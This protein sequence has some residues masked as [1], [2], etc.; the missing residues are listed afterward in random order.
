MERHVLARQ[1]VR[2]DDDV[3]LPLTEICEDGAKLLRRAS[4]G[5]VV[6]TD[7]EVLQSL[8]EG[9]VVLV[10]QD[11]RR[12]EDG[13]LLAVGGSLEGGTHGYLRLPEADIPAE[14]TVHRIGALH[15]GLHSGDGSG[16]VGGVFE[17]ERCLELVLEVGVGAE[18]K[19]L[20]L[21]ALGV[22][23]YQITGDVLDALLRAL[24]DPLPCP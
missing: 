20:R 11:R 14:Q 13:D 23:T 5:D 16:L 17:G 18:G 9:A 1:A 7:G 24:L 15:I 10:R 21:T 6:D 22:E 2:A 19:A 4:T 8:G 12:D 3:D